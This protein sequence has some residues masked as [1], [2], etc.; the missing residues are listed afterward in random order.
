MLH[1]WKIAAA[2]T[3]TMAESLIKMTWD[4]VESIRNLDFYAII[5]HILGY[6]CGNF[7]ENHKSK[8]CASFVDGCGCMNA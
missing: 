5:N 8:Y 4:L 6:C 3:G 2:C 1:R 7:A